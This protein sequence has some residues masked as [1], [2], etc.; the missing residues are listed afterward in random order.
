MVHDT[1]DR[2]I[3]EE[4]LRRSNE[5]LALLSGIT[6]HDIKNQLTVLGGNLA[7][8]KAQTNDPKVLQRIEKLEKVDENLRDQI[9]FTKDYQELGTASP[10]WQ[11]LKGLLDNVKRPEIERTTLGRTIEGLEIFADPMLIKVL[12]NLMENSAKY[13]GR[14]FNITFD[15]SEE[16]DGFVLT[17]SDDGNGVAYEEKDL[18]FKKGFGKGNR[19]WA[20]SVM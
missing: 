6:R 8:M 1:T 11:N 12:Y 17:Y 3:L 4:G 20:L 14:P 5:K 2:R 13:A 15:G 16:K 9:E 10:H 7:L 18:I 19:T